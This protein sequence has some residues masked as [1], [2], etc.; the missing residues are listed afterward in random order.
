MS[1]TVQ[2]TDLEQIQ[3]DT[4]SPEVDVK[5]E[6]Q[7]IGG[8]DQLHD[9]LDAMADSMD[10]TGFKCVH[11]KCGLVHEHDTTKHRGGDSFDMSEDEASQMEANS[12]CHCGLNDAAR[13]GV[14]GAPSPSRANDKAPI[15]DSMTRHLDRSL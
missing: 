12:V 6:R 14:E 13:S 8:V 4:T 3:K 9:E 5:V 10:V 11:E 2:R 15:P 1:E 7:E